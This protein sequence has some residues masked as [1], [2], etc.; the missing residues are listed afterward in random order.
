MTNLA[1]ASHK[2]SM[3]SSRLTKTQKSSWPS[4]ISWKVSG[5]WIV[6]SARNRILLRCYCN[7]LTS[8]YKKWPPYPS[9]WGGLTPHCIFAWPQRHL[10]MW[11]SNIS[12]HWLIRYHHTNLKNTLSATQ[13]S[14]RRERPRTTAPRTPSRGRTCR[15]TS[16]GAGMIRPGG[17]TGGGGDDR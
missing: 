7:L 12:K 9:K 4:G 11:L 15:S 13:A 6:P 10:A 14:G 3:R 2:S 16:P 8:Q 17:A 1:V 5:R